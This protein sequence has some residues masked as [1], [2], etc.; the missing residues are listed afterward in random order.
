MRLVF[1]V[2]LLGGLTACAAVE[3]PPEPKPEPPSIPL[4]EPDN[5]GP[6]CGYAARLAAN[7]DAD[8][9]QKASVAAL[10]S[11]RGC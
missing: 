9:A 8:P 4:F 5:T 3:A 7:P 1:A 2:L 6:W 10:A 11:D